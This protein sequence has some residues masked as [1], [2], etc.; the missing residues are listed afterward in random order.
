MTLL[1][2]WSS[3]ADNEVCLERSCSVEDE[4]AARA[5]RVFYAHAP[6]VYNLARRMLGNEADAEDV[7]QEVLLRVLHKLDSFRG[8]GRLT[9]WL[10]R[11]TVN[12][13]LEHRRKSLRR[14]E[15]EMDVPLAEQIHE[16]SEANACPAQRLL[17]GEMREMIEQAIARLPELYREVYVLADIE[18]L[19]NAEIGEILHLGVA[20]VKSRLRRARLMMREALGGRAWE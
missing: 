6:R 18:E 3:V 13:S 7:T 9:T 14:R 20:A 11:V 10:H 2:Y 8:E 16:T 1:D 15:H 12:A 17:D 5:E 4:S 19:S